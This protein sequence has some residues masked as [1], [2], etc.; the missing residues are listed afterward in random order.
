MQ[1]NDLMPHVES[2]PAP[3]DL[4]AESRNET[5]SVPGQFNDIDTTL[6]QTTTEEGAFRGGMGFVMIVRYTD[7]PV[8]PYDELMMVPGDFKNPSGTQRP[9]ISRIFVSTLAS[10]YNGRRNWNIPKELANFT[11]TSNPNDHRITE[12]R[13]FAATSYSPVTYAT[14]PF[15]A[16]NIKS[17]MWPFPAIPMNLKYSPVSMTLVQPP[18]DAAQDSSRPWLIGTSEWNMF[19]LVDYKGRVK[20]VRWEG[21]IEDDDAVSRRRTRGKMANGKEFPDVTPYRVGIFW[22]DVTMKFLEGTVPG[23]PHM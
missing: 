3:W 16:V 14:K 2:S 22:Q 4:K 7:S 1:D 23:L 6:S 18:L 5:V 19:T 15:F 9:R 17:V 8:G 11:F 21:A 10:V 13:V 20:P 12:M